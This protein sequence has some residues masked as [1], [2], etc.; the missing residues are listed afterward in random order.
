MTIRRSFTAGLLISLAGVAFAT[1]P[2]AQPAQNP[3]LVSVLQALLT[4]YEGCILEKYE[5][6]QTANLQ[7][8]DTGVTC[9]AGN[10]C[11]LAQRSA[12]F[13]NLNA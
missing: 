2:E 11:T 5:T 8:R 4:K 13:A 9:M 3:Q 1:K 7:V 10:I 6:S 12:T